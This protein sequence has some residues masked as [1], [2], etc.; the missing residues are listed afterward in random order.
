MVFAQELKESQNYYDVLYRARKC[1][2]LSIPYFVL[3]ILCVFDFILEAFVLIFELL[4]LFVLLFFW[5]NILL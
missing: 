2:F 4:K 5:I 3:H 1:H